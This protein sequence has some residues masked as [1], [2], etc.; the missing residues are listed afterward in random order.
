MAP[1]IFGGFGSRLVKH[2]FFYFLFLFETFL[3]VHSHIVQN[4]LEHMNEL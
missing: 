3:F 1:E 4:A 2:R